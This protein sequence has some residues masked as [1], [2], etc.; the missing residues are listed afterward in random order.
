MSDTSTLERI[1]EP[2]VDAIQ[3]RLQEIKPTIE[4]NSRIVLLQVKHVRQ[5]TNL[6]WAAAL[7]SWLQV[8]LGRPLWNQDDLASMFVEWT[9]GVGITKLGLQEV[10]NHR[11]IRMQFKVFSSVDP[12]C[13][14]PVEFDYVFIRDKLKANKYLYVFY[15]LSPGGPAHACVVYGAYMRDWETHLLVMDPLEYR[16]G[17]RPLTNYINTDVVIAAWAR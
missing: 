4:K 9:N 6:C 8:T 5:R 2:V 13:P 17:E 14:K 12:G 10:M 15:N 7:E 3:K 11:E 16:N 1:L